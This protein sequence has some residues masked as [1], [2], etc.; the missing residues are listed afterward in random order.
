MASMK[1]YLS[2]VL[3]HLECGHYL[4][5]T[6]FSQFLGKKRSG[7]EVRVLYQVCLLGDF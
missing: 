6:M 2:G 1:T 5:A 3:E 7:E 4:D